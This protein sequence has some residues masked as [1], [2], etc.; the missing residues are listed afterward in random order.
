MNYAYDHIIANYPGV[1]LA[2]P[3]G[4]YMLFLNCEGWCKAHNITIDELQKKGAEVGVMWQDGRSFHEPYGI[5]M[6]LASPYSRI[7]E[8]FERLDKYVFVD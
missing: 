6:N 7:V 5:R 2:K 8:A 1:T 4:T 3:Q